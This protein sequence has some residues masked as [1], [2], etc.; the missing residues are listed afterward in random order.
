ML[1]L[2]SWYLFCVKRRTK[3]FTRIITCDLQHNLPKRVPLLSLCSVWRH[4]ALERVTCS[5]FATGSWVLGIRNTKPQTLYLHPLMF[6]GSHKLKSPLPST[7][8]L[9]AF[10][11]S[12][13]W[14]ALRS[15]ILPFNSTDCR[16]V[17]QI[18]CRWHKFH[19]WRRSGTA[20]VEPQEL[21]TGLWV[22]VRVHLANSLHHGKCCSNSD[23]ELEEGRGR[24]RIYQTW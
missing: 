13:G 9:E 10:L 19:P 15:T 11:Q 20:L 22:A 21:E 1:V 6:F 17:C 4:R 8:G 16:P 3:C 5:R 23:V 12:V 14:A 2:F 7:E 18:L 24:D